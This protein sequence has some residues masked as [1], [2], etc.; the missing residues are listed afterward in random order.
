ML[1][2]FDKHNKIT[3]KGILHYNCEE[4]LR[5]PTELDHSVARK[6]VYSGIKLPRLSLRGGREYHKSR[7]S[8]ASFK[9]TGRGWG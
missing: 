5:E 1:L 6:Q 9:R 3:I 4:G 8:L 2:T 7:S